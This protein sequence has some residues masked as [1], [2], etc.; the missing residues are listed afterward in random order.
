MSDS[1]PIR[2]ARRPARAPFAMAGLLVV[3]AALVFAPA[4]MAKPKGEFSNFTNCPLSVSGVNECV[5]GQI[6]SGE[7]HFGTA[8]VPI[9]KTITLQGGLIVTEKAETFVNATEGA[10]LSKTPEGVPGGFEGQGVTETL[11][12]VGTVAMSRT[13]L[14]AGKGVALTLPVRIHL[15]S[16][17]FGEACFIGSSTS[18]ITLNLTTGTTSPPAPNKP[19]VGKPGTLET[20][21]TG[22]LLIYSGDS[23]VENSFSVPVTKGCGGSLESLIDPLLN[24][25]YG[26]PSAGGHNTVIFNGTTKFATAEA[27]RNSE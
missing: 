6:S 27:V 4:A 12:P 1:D 20:K 14:A 22:A 17:G 26:L 5:Y 7:L 24:S 16:T 3:L 18:P 19:I 21:E 11:E 23:L 8:S 10:T 2:P 15:N 13:N 25:K 9:I